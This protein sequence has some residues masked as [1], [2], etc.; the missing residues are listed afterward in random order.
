VAVANDGQVKINKV[1]A[2][3]DIGSQVINPTA[4]LNLTQGGILD[5]FGEALNQK[6]TIENG[7]AVQ[8]NFDAFEPLRMTQAP[9][10]EVHFLS[11]DNSPTGLG[12]P[13]LPP[14]IPALCNAIFAATGKRIR[15][16]PIDQALLKA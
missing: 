13:P 6:I 5:G 7:R 14:A 4:A 3:G 12:E 11:T 2:V 9:P 1:W 15:T 10:I 8:A 16:L